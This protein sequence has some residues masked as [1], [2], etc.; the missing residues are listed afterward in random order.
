MSSALGGIVKEPPRPSTVMVV[1]FPADTRNELGIKTRS[2]GGMETVYVPPAPIV[3]LS[4]SAGRRDG[5][6]LAVSFHSPSTP[7][8]QAMES[9]PRTA[10]GATAAASEN[11]TNPM[12][13]Q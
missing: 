5:F 7:D 3:T 2:P 9:A 13:R 4:P 12:K 11:A 6:H 10:C 8:L 1:P